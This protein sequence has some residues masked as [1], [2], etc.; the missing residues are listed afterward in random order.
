[1]DFPIA[2]VTLEGRIPDI[3][4]PCTHLM[5]NCDSLPI[6]IY[7]P[8]PKVCKNGWPYAIN[9]PKVNKIIGTCTSG[10]VC[11]YCHRYHPVWSKQCLYY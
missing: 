10:S 6:K 2:I 8:D 5:L 9:L 1:M 4:L 3:E 11:V 7:I